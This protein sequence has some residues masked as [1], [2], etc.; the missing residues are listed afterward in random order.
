MKGRS[1]SPLFFPPL[2]AVGFPFHILLFYGFSLVIKFLPFGQSQLN[3]GLTALEVKFERDYGQT[4]FLDLPDHPP[5]F[6]F[7]QEELS[8][9][10]RVLLI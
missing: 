6:L 9:P 1:I 3:L 8:G 2:L 5:D 4:F 7:M 10:G